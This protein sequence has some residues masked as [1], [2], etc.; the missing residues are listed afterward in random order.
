MKLRRLSLL[1]ATV[2]ISFTGNA[3]HDPLQPYRGTAGKTLADTK[4][5]FPERQVAVK[6]SPN[7]VWIL[8]DDV[9]F[10]AISSFGG[11]INTPNI[12]SLAYNGLRYTNFHTT[13]ICAPTR[14]ALLTGRNHHSVHMGL[15]PDNAVGTP[16]YDGII[17]F[18][19]A[20][21]AEILKENGYNTYALGKWHITPIT[22][23]TGSGPF[24]RWPTG[25]GFDHFYGYPFRGSSDQ[26][27]PQIWENTR[28]DRTDTQGKHF[29]TL[30][31]DRA[32]RLVSEQKSS[33]PEKPFFLYIATGAGHAPHQVAPEWSNKYKGKFDGGWDQYRDQVLARQV[34][35]GIVPNHTVVP[36]RNAGIKEWNA[37]P[38]DEKKL[39]ARFMEVYAGFLEHTDYEIGRV[40]KHL[41]KIGQLENTIIMISVGDNGGSKEGTTVGVV[42]SLDPSLTDEQ[43]LKYNIDNIDKIGTEFSKANYPLGWAMA[44]NTPFRQWKQDANTEGGTRNPFIIYYPKGIKDKG[45]IRDQYSHVIDVLPTTL[46]LIKAD[47]PVAINGYKQEGIEGTSL[48]YSI[49]DAKAPSKHTI[50]YYEVKGSRSVYSNGWKAGTLHQAG[51]DFAKD[52]WE[53]YNLNEDFNERVNLAA[54]YPEKLKEL[55]TLFDEQAVRFNIYPLKD[56]STPI[57]P[58]RP[59]DGR[60]H[61]VF[62][63]DNTTLVELAAPEFRNTSFDITADVVLPGTST[64]GVLLSTGGRESGLSLFLQQ[65]K[66][67]FTYNNGWSTYTVSSGALM[68]K[69]GKALFKVQY[70]FSAQSKSGVATLYL[71]EVKVG[72]GKVQKVGTTLFGHEGL[73]VGLDD[74]TP[75]SP[76]Y[77]VPY[78]FTGSINQVTIDLKPSAATSLGMR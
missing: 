50:Q 61:I 39:Y 23:L 68:L 30:L 9:G 71:N 55:Q 26:W 52:V 70:A 6:G 53:L 27:H 25:R 10:G 19:K 66:L 36:V 78:G 14:A 37:L 22:D 51:S 40:V 2:A 63:P 29:T 62:Y 57:F 75:V 49:N 35:L 20:T 17:P 59:Y 41:R 13:A 18:E 31:A 54:K 34:K 45:G 21:V 69:P 3:Q 74:L 43:V 7:V 56:L 72:E 38:A 44:T 65:G 5:S 8:L 46:E 15:F 24:N 67:H 28:R 60:Q 47:V 58:P 12:D 48:V 64:E 42:N 33:S 76:T 1:I 77:S 73:N 16:G 32:I 4:Q 11:L